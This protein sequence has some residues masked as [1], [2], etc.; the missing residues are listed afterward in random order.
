[1]KRLFQ[2]LLFGFAACLI[3]VAL[4]P[5]V[6]SSSWKC[7][8]IKE[9]KIMEEM[10]Q[11]LIWALARGHCLTE[12]L[13][14]LVLAVASCVDT[15][16]CHLIPVESSRSREEQSYSC[17]KFMKP[18]GYPLYSFIMRD[19]PSREEFTHQ[20]AQALSPLLGNSSYNEKL[21]WSTELGQREWFDLN[22]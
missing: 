16:F 3:I 14:V 17:L 11:L 10:G 6:F 5:A 15:H 20:P 4:L 8:E 9:K 19:S 7:Y 18:L 21:S 1:M 12:D 22:T 13:A 2:R